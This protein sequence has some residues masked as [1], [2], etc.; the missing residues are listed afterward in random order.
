MTNADVLEK[1]QSRPKMAEIVNA[2]PVAT[3]IDLH[4][5]PIDTP[6]SASAKR[7]RHYK[8]SGGLRI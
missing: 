5:P 2:R 1:D 6:Q 8:Q 4:H 3:R 7:M